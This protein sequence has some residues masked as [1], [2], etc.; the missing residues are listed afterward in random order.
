MGIVVIILL[1]SL[2][3]TLNFHPTEDE[4][5]RRWIVTCLWTMI[6]VLILAFVTSKWSA[7]LAPYTAVA[8]IFGSVFC[9]CMYFVHRGRF[10]KKLA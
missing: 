8:A 7:P 6:F 9:W 3:I 10:E 4:L 2:S 1:C 5:R